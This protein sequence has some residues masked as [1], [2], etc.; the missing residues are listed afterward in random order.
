MRLL[1]GFISLLLLFAN[2]GYADED[3]SNA[4]VVYRGKDALV[5]L[6]EFFTRYENHNFYEGCNLYYEKHDGEDEYAIIKVLDANAQTS[7]SI[8]T[9]E[10]QFQ[11]SNFSLIG[12]DKEVEEDSFEV[13]EEGD[14]TTIKLKVNRYLFGKNRINLFPIFGSSSKTIG[15]IQR[16]LE[17]E[18]DGSLVQRVEFHDTYYRLVMGTYVPYKKKVLV[19]CN[20][21]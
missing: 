17:M 18:R 7:V 19:N 6:K 20:H 14:I 3:N 8:T 21:Q 12:G 2:T 16:T 4:A 11:L 9:Y 13:S 1:C 15:Y 10:K 5:R